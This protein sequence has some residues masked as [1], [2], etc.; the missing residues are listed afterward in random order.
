MEKY[1]I[2][3]LVK[4]ARQDVGLKQSDAREGVMSPSA[5][6]KMENGYKILSANELLAIL[7][8]LNISSVDFFSNY[9]EPLYELDNRKK[10]KF[11]YTNKDVNDNLEK[12][13]DM[14]RELEKKFDEL[15]TRDISVFIDIKSLLHADFP[16][17]ISPVSPKELKELKNILLRNSRNKLLREDYKIA[18]QLVSG[19]KSK[20][21]K[22]LFEMIFPISQNTFL[23]SYTKRYIVDIMINALTVVQHAKEMEVFEEILSVV[24]SHSFLYDDSYYY[25]ANL[26]FLENIHYF[27]KDGTVE[28]LSN[29]LKVIDAVEILGDDSTAKTLRDELDMLVKNN[30]SRGYMK[31]RML[32][33]KK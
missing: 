17:I 30:D 14:Y 26:A 1:H 3:A 24:R 4:N 25:R 28:N 15:S 5:Y 22:E 10:L 21:I 29:A 7:V 32:I 13:F 23:D 2:N 33:T 18:A 19:L 20:E 27:L 16:N 6:S 31:N 8:N 11:L 9:V 12:I